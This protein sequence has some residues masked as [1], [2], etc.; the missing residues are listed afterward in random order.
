MDICLVRHKSYL[1]SCTEAQTVIYLVRQ[2]LSLCLLAKDLPQLSTLR[3][4]KRV[5]EG[6]NQPSPHFVIWW[7]CHNYR[8]FRCTSLGDLIFHYHFDL[9]IQWYPGRWHTEFAGPSGLLPQHN[10]RKKFSFLVK[11]LSNLYNCLSTIF[12]KWNWVSYEFFRFIGCFGHSPVNGSACSHGQ[13]LRLVTFRSESHV[14]CRRCDSIHSIWSRTCDI[15]KT[16]AQAVW[17]PAT[18]NNGELSAIFTWKG[19]YDV[20]YECYIFFIILSVIVLP[21]FS[22]T[23]AY[24]FFSHQLFK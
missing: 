17:E 20:K 24:Q 14:V 9:S 3:P 22:S 12:L 11:V 19:S 21:K 23:F 13:S 18:L 16:V 1:G 7:S 8:L 4:V 5:S 15:L 10:S 6:T 2:D